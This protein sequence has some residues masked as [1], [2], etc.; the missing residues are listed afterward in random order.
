MEDKQSG[1]ITQFFGKIGDFWN[2]SEK[3]LSKPMIDPKKYK[4]A[5]EYL[6]E[7]LNTKFNNIE[8]AD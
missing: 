3:P 1:K 7:Q 8:L 6:A 2:K 4:F 5:E